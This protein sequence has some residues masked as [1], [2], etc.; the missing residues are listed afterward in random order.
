MRSIEKKSKTVFEITCPNGETLK[1]SSHRPYRYALIY[2]AGEGQL[3]RQSRNS[4]AK[5]RYSIEMMSEKPIPASRLATNCFQAVLTERDGNPVDVSNETPTKR[6]RRSSR[7]CVRTIEVSLT[8]E[9]IDKVNAD[10]QKSWTYTA[11]FLALRGVIEISLKCGKDFMGE[12]YVMARKSL[13]QYGFDKDDQIAKFQ[14][15]ILIDA[16]KQKPE[17]EKSSEQKTENP[18]QQ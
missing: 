2:D 18:F 11:R 7:R 10:L 9:I 1:T 14:L 3:A 5:S 17:P 8:Q 16:F 4:L 12:K 13:D 15:D 6:T